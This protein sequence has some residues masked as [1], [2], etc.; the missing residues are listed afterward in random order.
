MDKVTLTAS[1]RTVL[2]R[3]VKTLR[4]QGSIPANIFG[5]KVKSQAVQVVEKEFS[6]VFSK[7]GETGLV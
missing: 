4:K 1:K 3:K 6:G 7:V 2:G 5:K